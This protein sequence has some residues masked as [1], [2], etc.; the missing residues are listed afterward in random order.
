M[1]RTITIVGYLALLFGF[2]A[3]I[4]AFIKL[5]WPLIAVIAGF[6]GF[7]FSSIY[8]LLNARHRVNEK[9]LNP[10]MIGLLLSSVPILFFFILVFFKR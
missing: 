7:L 4:F 1:T 6:L 9:A 2:T 8:I 5:Y 10:G 3:S